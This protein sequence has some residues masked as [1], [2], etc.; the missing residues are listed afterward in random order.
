MGSLG[1]QSTRQVLQ[2]NENRPPKP[3]LRGGCLAETYRGCGASSTGRLGVWSM[4][5]DLN[6]RIRSL[7]RKDRVEEE[8]DD[9]LRF[10]LDHQLQKYVSS[11][12]SREEALRHIRLEFG[13]IDQVKE[14]CR[15]A[16]GIAV[17]T[18]VA[19]DVRYGLRILRR[20]PGF[21]AMT[22]LI[23]ALGIGAN[24][25]V[26]SILDAVLL[27]P[28]PYKNA[29]RLVVVWQR[30]P[31]EK[32]GMVFDTYRMFDEWSR[33]SHSFEKLAA[34]TWARSGALLSWKGQ[35][36]DVMTV[37]ASVEFVYLH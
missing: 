14:Q 24:T 10:H 22:M 6:I 15:D 32:V 8:L 33:S 5:S 29:D 13:T 31:P 18:T 37:P 12:M 1:K 4:W 26:F 2:L 20:S 34:A 7:F 35:V 27:R 23:L 11:G 9:E 28:L 25:A 19:Q 3:R 21:T 17:L 36:K 16:Q 30:V